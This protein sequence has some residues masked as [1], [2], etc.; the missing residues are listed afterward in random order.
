MIV[1]VTDADRAIS[2]LKKVALTKVSST[3]ISISDKNQKA[4]LQTWADKVDKKEGFDWWEYKTMLDFVNAE[5]KTRGGKIT[6]NVG[7][8]LELGQLLNKLSS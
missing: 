4:L 1:K 7:G 6:Y 8:T 2:I 3:S 5:I